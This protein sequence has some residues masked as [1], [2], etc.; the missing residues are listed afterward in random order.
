VQKRKLIRL[1]GV[2]LTVPELDELQRLARED[3]VGVSTWIR[4][5][6]G[7]ELRRRGHA[8]TRAA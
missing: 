4:L 8:T 6:I 3:C 7:R 5:A 1:I 2:R